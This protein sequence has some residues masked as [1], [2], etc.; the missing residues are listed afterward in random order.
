MK[1]TGFRIS[2]VLLLILININV[3]AQR[4]RHPVGTIKVTTE[5]P[6]YLVID[7]MS[8]KEMTIYHQVVIEGIDTGSHFLFFTH[9][10]LS[11]HRKILVGTGQTYQYVIRPDSLVLNLTT[12]SK[13]ITGSKSTIHSYYIPKTKGLSCLAMIGFSS[14]KGFSYFNGMIVT[15]Y[16]FSPIFSLGGGTGY[17]RMYSTFNEY[18]FLLFG[19]ST[20]THSTG[21]SVPY[22]PVFIDIRLNLIKKRVIPY[23]SADIGCSFPVSKNINGSYTKEINFLGYVESYQHLFHIDKI[24]PGFY[25]AINPGL[26]IFLYSKYYLDISMGLDMCIN[27]FKGTDEVLP[28]GSEPGSVES[29]NKTKILSCFH[30]NVGF[31][32]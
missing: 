25:L 4:K 8:A 3:M 14:N 9:D 31:G 26:K 29:I 13:L 28:T 19:S 22:I 17:L 7:T 11:L 24:N 20:I 10:S 15:G 23:F 27:K 1:K 5:I 6:G 12:K 30:M 16:Q 21:F 18:V 32:F 2:I